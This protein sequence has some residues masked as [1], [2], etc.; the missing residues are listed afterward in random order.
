MATVYYQKSQCP[1]S[2]DKVVKELKVCKWK[3]NLFNYWCF[4]MPACWSWRSHI[5]LKICPDGYNSQYFPYTWI[6]HQII[7][8]CV[9]T[10]LQIVCSGALLQL[11]A[12]ST[13]SHLPPWRLRQWMV[14]TIITH[15][16][17][18]QPIICYVVI[19]SLQPPHWLPTCHWL[20]LWWCRRAQMT[21]TMVL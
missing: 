10:H 4:D 5:F 12:I 9:H 13:I 1:D 3:W 21:G 18:L 16:Q 7:K 19:D 2:S 20:L 6:K 8:F 14:S 17:A 11:S 15:W